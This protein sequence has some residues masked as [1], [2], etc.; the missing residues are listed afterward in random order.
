MSG[1]RSMGS[2]VTAIKPRTSTIKSS[3]IVKI[4]R[5]EPL[6]VFPLDDAYLDGLEKRLLVFRVGEEDSGLGSPLDKGAERHQLGLVAVGEFDLGVDEEAGFEGVA[7]VL[8]I[9]LDPGLARCFLEEGRH[10]GDCSLKGPPR[11][12]GAGH[13][14]IRPGGA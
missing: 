8:D 9:D 2:R 13:D 3:M 5:G 4:G 6:G 10:S 11:E 1:M 7:I 14:T 12:G